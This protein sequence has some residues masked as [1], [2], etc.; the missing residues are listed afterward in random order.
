MI[1]VYITTLLICLVGALLKLKNKALQYIVLGL[2]T[3]LM[4]R[5]ALTLDTAN[6]YNR[7]QRASGSSFEDKYEPGYFLLEKIGLFL[8]A[9]YIQFRIVTVFISLLL[10]NKLVNKVT[11][12][13]VFLFYFVYCLFFIFIDTV[14]LRSFIS[15]SIVIYA[16]NYLIYSTRFKK[17]I[18]YS[19]LVFLASTIHISSLAYLVFALIGLKNRKR[20]AKAVAFVSLISVVFIFIGGNNLGVVKVVINIISGDSSRLSAYGETSVKFGFLYPFTLQLISVFVVFVMSEFINKEYKSCLNSNSLT[21]KVINRK[22]V[23]NVFLLINVI[24][25]V[26][27]PLYMFHLQFIRLARGV[28]MINIMV[29][30]LMFVKYERVK[31]EKIIVAVVVASLVLYWF[32]YTYVLSDHVDDIIIPFFQDATI[33]N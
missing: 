17:V 20:L 27:F 29:L 28:L 22:N 26:Y 15:L 8:G 13:K 10:I 23:I 19:F 30:V 1:L 32:F 4:G 5:G 21:M 16:L 11:E 18:V 9:D 25:I 33:L 31:N 2:I 24:S 14:Q 3:H 12:K 6:Y 7:Y